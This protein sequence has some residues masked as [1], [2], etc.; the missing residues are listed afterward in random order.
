MLLTVEDLRELRVD[1]SCYYCLSPLHPLSGGLDRI[2]N[3]KG[4]TRDNVLP[5]CSMCNDAR[6][7]LLT[8]AEFKAAMS[9]RLAALPAG[10]SPWD[11]YSW[12]SVSRG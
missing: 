2:D 6:G 1:K 4:Y 9:L 12:R 7:H 11:G 5:C 3:A 10:A 8:V